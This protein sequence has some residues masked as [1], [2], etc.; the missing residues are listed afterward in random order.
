MKM[1]HYIWLNVYRHETTKTKERIYLFHVL[2]S[3]ANSRRTLFAYS[4]Y[5]VVRV[6]ILIQTVV[7]HLFSIY[8]RANRAVLKHDL[9][10]FK[11]IHFAVNI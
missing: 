5:T 7:S 2:K 1:K 9:F 8:Q 3:T 6:S 10:F 4:F 11:Y